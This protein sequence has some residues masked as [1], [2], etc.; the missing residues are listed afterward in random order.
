MVNQTA[1]HYWITKNFDFKGHNTNCPVHDD[2]NASCSVS[3]ENDRCQ[4]FCHTCGKDDGRAY[5]AFLEMY[6]ASNPHE[7]IPQ[8]ESREKSKNKIK[9]VDYE[10]RTANF[11]DV[12]SPAVAK[13][14]LYARKTLKSDSPVDNADT[15]IHWY[16]DSIGEKIG[17]GVLRVKLLDGKKM[18]YPFYH[19]TK[20]DW[21]FKH[22]TDMHGDKIKILP[23]GF[24][25][26]Y[27]KHDTGKPVVIV[28][29]EK[30]ADAINSI[31]GKPYIAL[32]GL[33]G[34][35]GANTNW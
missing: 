9:K 34:S 15:L 22:P 35:N 10:P 8:E 27:H 28:E 19:T 21:S 1:L 18:F 4:V 12:S 13:Q 11:L 29:G 24:N 16:H 2:S 23:Y 25:N 33:G 7:D 26:L 14:I 32:C 5:K 20:D 3:L 6:K 17:F 31:P 30:T